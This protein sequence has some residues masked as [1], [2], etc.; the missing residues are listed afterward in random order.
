M[1]IFKRLF[2]KPKPFIQEDWSNAKEVMNQQMKKQGEYLG[3]TIYSTPLGL[4][5]GFPKLTKTELLAL[6]SCIDFAT[7]AV[8]IIRIEPVLRPAYALKALTDKGYLV[9]VKKGHYSL[10]FYR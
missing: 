5:K 10:S 7:K 8:K 1:N 6:N 4:V 2:K 3:L 9:R